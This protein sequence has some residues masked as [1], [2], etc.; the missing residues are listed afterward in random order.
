MTVYSTLRATGYSGPPPNAA[1]FATKPVTI[2]PLI[3]NTIMAL[4]NVVDVV[5]AGNQKEAV[6]GGA[7]PLGNLSGP[8][9]NIFGE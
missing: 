1:L 6:K 2:N 9:A 5:L 8:M 4:P 3:T 7:T